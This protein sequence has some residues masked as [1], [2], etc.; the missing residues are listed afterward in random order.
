M[1]QHITHLTIYPIKSTQGYHLSQADV[2]LQGLAFDREYMLTDLHGKFITARK[3]PALFA[4]S[5]YNYPD[6]L[7]VK[8]QDN[9]QLIVTKQDFIQADRCQVWQSQF[10]SQIAKADINDWFSEKLNYPVQLRWLGSSSQRYLKHYPQNTVSFADSY[11]ILLVNLT[12]LKALEQQCGVTLD[13]AQF[14]GN[15]IIESNV[16]F[17]E[18]KWRKI[19]IGDVI[20]IH[21]QPSTRCMLTTRHPLT[22]EQHPHLEPFRTLKK[23]HTNEQGEPIFGI[24]LLPLNSGTIKAG[25]PIII[26]E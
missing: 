11:P 3:E 21:T 8:H 26:L 14:R 15:I 22:A 2:T 9:S 4:F 19:Q 1:S 20:F 16:A 6:Y 17:I 18:E 10:I 5:A 12:S 25:D 24:N 23:W 13:I 7:L